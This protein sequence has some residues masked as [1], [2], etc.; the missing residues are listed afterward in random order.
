[1]KKKGSNRWKMDG[2]VNRANIRE[3]TKT[4]GEN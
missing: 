1:M 2:K 4:K 3:S